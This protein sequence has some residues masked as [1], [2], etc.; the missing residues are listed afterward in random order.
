M[1]DGSTPQAYLWNFDDP[2]SGALNTATSSS[3]SHI[4]NTVGPFNVNLQVTSNNSCV[5]DT[6][7]LISNIHPQPLA[8]FTVDKTEVCVGGSFT[9]NDNTNY[10]DGTASSWNWTLK[11]GNTRTISSFTHTYTGAQTYDVELYT[12]N[13]HGCRSTT[14]IKP[15][16]V[17]PYPVVD[18]GPDRLVL[19]GGQITLNPVVTGNDLAYLWTPNQYI[20]GSNTI[21]NLV[22]NGVDDI[23]YL[24]TVTARGNCTDTSSVFIKVLKFPSIPNIFSPNG[25]GVHDKWI[26][27]YLDTYP[28]STVDIYNRYGQQIF[29]SVGYTVP[30]DGTVNGNPVPVGTYY[31]IVDPKNG[32]KLMTGYVDVIR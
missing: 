2:A 1:P 6:S 5:H 21:K 12:I 10:M 7:I 17:H 15:V 27:D 8:D 20:A 25:D 24:L 31:Y 11:D 16:T 3:P 23:R 26:I 9:F 29:H 30:W 32:R 22:V 19:E 4:Y 18:A 14:A 28:G 13:S